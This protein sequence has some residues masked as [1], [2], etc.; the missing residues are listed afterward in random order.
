MNI[1]S[2]GIAPE[3]HRVVEVWRNIWRSSSPTSAQA[4]TLKAGCPVPCP[5]GFWISPKRDKSGQHAQISDVQ[6]KPVHTIFC[7]CFLYCYWALW[8]EP[9]FLLSALPV[10]VFVYIDEILHKH[11]LLEVEQS[12]LSSSPN[13][14]GALAPS[15]FLWSLIGLSPVA[16]H[17]SCTRGPILD[18][19]LQA[20]HIFLI[21]FCYTIIGNITCATMTV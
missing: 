19:V 18:T 1:M 9:G 2:I 14:R 17:L 15:K 10:Q 7:H 21:A 12:L 13:R 6:R 16:P 3:N 8:K 11:P 5:D 20:W 4:K